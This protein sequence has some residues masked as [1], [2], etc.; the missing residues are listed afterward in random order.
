MGAK[1][2]KA[3]EEVATRNRIEIK[4]LA[5]SGVIAN[6]RPNN[7]ELEMRAGSETVACDNQN[8]TKRAGKGRV[9][10]LFVL[11]GHLDI[12]KF[13]QP[14]RRATRNVEKRRQVPGETEGDT[15][16]GADTSAIPTG[17][18]SDPIS[19]DEDVQSSVAKPDPTQKTRGEANRDDQNVFGA[20]AELSSGKPVLYIDVPEH[21]GRIKLVGSVVF[22]EAPLL[23][24]K[25]NAATSKNTDVECSNFFDNMVVFD[26]VSWVDDDK[27]SAADTD[28]TRSNTKV[29]AIDV[30]KEMEKFASRLM[31]SD[32]ELKAE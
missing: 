16:E 32:G 10:F 29:E 18:H 1:T 17:G 24:L 28:E 19:I 23:T 27:R 25:L 3:M 21:G 26:N 5:K 11:P 4:K 15:K 30:R 14:R 2:A 31:Q 6:E 13:A 20:I 8:V 22:P 12:L 9:R 7:R